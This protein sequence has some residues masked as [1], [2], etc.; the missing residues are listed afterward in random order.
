[1]T[2]GERPSR[3]CTFDVKSEKMTVLKSDEDRGI[4]IP[5]SNAELEECKNYTPINTQKTKH[6]NVTMWQR[7]GASVTNSYVRDIC[8]PKRPALPNFL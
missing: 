8:R 6:G 1:M 7:V 4:N 2:P 5:S 3:T